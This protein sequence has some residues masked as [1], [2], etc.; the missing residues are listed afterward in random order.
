MNRNAWLK[1]TPVMPSR[2]WSLVRRWNM[3][4]RPVR[5]TVVRGFWSVV[6]SVPRSRSPV[7]GTIPH[8]STL[9]PVVRFHVDASRPKFTDIPLHKYPR[10]TIPLILAWDKKASPWTTPIP[11][12]PPTWD[13][14]S[15]LHFF[16]CNKRS[17]GDHS[18]LSKGAFREQ[19]RR[20]E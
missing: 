9:S 15:H 12:S 10:R 4:R 19:K 20:S 13:R 6:S 3:H 2:S 18:F 14:R 17:L 1:A 16:R 7:S 8:H 5:T 11:R